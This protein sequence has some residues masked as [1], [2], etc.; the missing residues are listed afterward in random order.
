MQHNIKNYVCYASSDLFAEPAGISIVSLL[1]NVKD[2][3]ITEIFLLD[4]GLSEESIARFR[5]IENS[6]GVKITLIRSKEII[7]S[8]RDNLGLSDFS[9]SMATYSRAFIDLIIPEYVD[10]LLYID[11]DT[12]VCDDVSDVFNIELNECVMAGIVGINQYAPLLTNKVWINP[13]LQLINHNST[14]FACGVVLYSLNNWRKSDCR[15]MI[16]SACSKISEYPYA[17]QTLIN[18]A[19]PEKLIYRLPAKY[20]S[21]LHELPA[22]CAREE[23]LRGGKLSEPEIIDAISNPVIHHYKGEYYRPWYYESL[24]RANDVFL[25]YKSI[26]PWKDVPLKH[27]SK[28]SG[29]DKTV[30]ITKIELMTLGKRQSIKNRSFLRLYDFISLNFRRLCRKYA[31]IRY[32]R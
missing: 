16:C 12:I 6:Y 26:S 17:D 1:E 13:E 15:R 7:E 27:L 32:G 24:S 2:N 4:Y 11:A 3:T 29:D 20:N 30:F 31:V 28:L 14:Y 5:E 25:K 19:I 23:L 18:N 9:G 21:W 8:E 22:C 10:K